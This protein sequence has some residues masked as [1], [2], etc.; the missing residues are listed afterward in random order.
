MDV[1]ITTKT[2]WAQINWRRETSKVA[3]LQQKIDCYSLDGNSAGVTATQKALIHSL[4]A[5]LLAVRRVN[6]DNRG[7]N[8]AGVG[9]DSIKSLTPHQQMKLAKTL[10]ING[11][12]SP[13]AQ[14][15]SQKLV[16]LKKGR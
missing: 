9:V 6:Q 7:K 12:A 4:S 15:A 14:C 16:Q 8:T 13:F 1:T 11:R 10:I 5:R 3:K 2:D